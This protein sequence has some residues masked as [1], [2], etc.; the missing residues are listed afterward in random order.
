MQKF[1]AIALLAI[2]FAAVLAPAAS[3]RTASTSFAPQTE[4]S[5]RPIWDY[6]RCNGYC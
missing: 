2:V 6:I 3:A 5:A 1:I 4:E